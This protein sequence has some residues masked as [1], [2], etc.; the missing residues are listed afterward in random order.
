MK[1]H[2][3][4]PRGYCQGVV[5]AIKISKQC[6]LDYPTTPIYILGMIVHNQFIV[7]ALEKMKIKTIDAKG[8]T[9]L[10]LLDQ[11]N[12]GV[13][14]I[15]AHGAGEDVTLKAKEKGL[16]VVDST[17]KDVTKTHDLI[18]HSLKENK[19]VLYIG[20]YQHPESEGAIAIDPKRIHLIENK[21]DLYHF[22]EP[23]KDYLVTNQT[24]MSLWDVKALCDEA[25]Q[26]SSRVTV[27]KETCHATTIRQE[28]M[29]SLPEE[30]DI[31]YVVGDPH[32]NNSTRLAHIASEHS[33]AKVSLIES[34]QDIDIEE[35]KNK[36]YAA[37]S[38]G[39]S[40]P[41]YLT[42]MVIKFLEQFDKEHP[43]T[44]IKP[45]IQLDKILQ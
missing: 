3:V 43:T 17:C 37:V 25:Q 4:V 15:T 26:I 24:T 7:D 18:R 27:A 39:A 20:K 21:E 34:I 13:V 33:K 14:I 32:S 40:T 12:E 9:R 42:N 45:E 23:D 10:E 44:W 36:K 16:I 5:N 31:L 29:A 11:I 41:T 22:I 2:K 30:V 35:L 28:A 8:K 19:E 1:V 38:S 6:R